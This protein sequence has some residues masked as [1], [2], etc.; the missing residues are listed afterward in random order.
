MHIYN[1][2]LS[3]FSYM[4]IPY[5]IDLHLFLGRGLAVAGGTQAE[6]GVFGAVPQVCYLG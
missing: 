5:Y 6:D 1:R 3:A 2:L 4:Q